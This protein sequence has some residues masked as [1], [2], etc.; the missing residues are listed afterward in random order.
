MAIGS[1]PPFDGTQATVSHSNPFT[2][3]FPQQP[4]LFFFI[5]LRS[6]TP[7]GMLESWNTGRMHIGELVGWV[8]GKIELTNP[9]KDEKFPSNLSIP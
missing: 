1:T 8:I 6:F 4:A 5:E 7:T 3:S 2:H 9:K